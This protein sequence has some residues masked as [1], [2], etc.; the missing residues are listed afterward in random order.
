MKEYKFVGK[1]N[2][3]LIAKYKNKI[4]TDEVILTHERLEH[5]YSYHSKDYEELK[6]Y[7]KSIIE[8]PDYIIEDTANKDTLIL[9]KN[10]IDINKKARIVIKLATEIDNKLYTKNSIITLMRQ[11]D[12]S[13]LQTLNNKGKIIFDKN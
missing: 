6:D 4:N 8:E 5:I 12:K 7:I 11:R 10:I 3:K 1:L 2:L 9:L 13:Y